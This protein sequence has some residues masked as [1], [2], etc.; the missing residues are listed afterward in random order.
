MEFRYAAIFRAL[1]VTFI[2]S[3]RL[4]STVSN[5]E[6]IKGSACADTTVIEQKNLLYVYTLPCRLS[7]G[8]FSRFFFPTFGELKQLILSD[9]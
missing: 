2:D 6:H 4:A 1:F 8:I 3:V 9:F 7:S 5:H